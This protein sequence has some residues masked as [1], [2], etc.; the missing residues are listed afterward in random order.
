MSANNI[1]EI[2]LNNDDSDSSSVVE[3]K[4]VQGPKKTDRNANQNEGNF[5]DTGLPNLNH[6]PEILSPPNDSSLNFS[7]EFQQK[8]AAGQFN[9]II[10]KEETAR[11]AEESEMIN[12][13]SDLDYHDGEFKS[14]LRHHKIYQCMKCDFAAFS[15]TSF[16]THTEAHNNNNSF[17]CPKCPFIAINKNTFRAHFICKHSNVKKPFQCQICHFSTYFQSAL[18]QHIKIHSADR[19]YECQYCPYAAISKAYL[20]IHLR[21]HFTQPKYPCSV[22]SF[23]ALSADQLKNHFICHNSEYQFETNN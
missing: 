1:I 10:L 13:S 12:L 11:F 15:R 20:A 3:I 14:T 22:C 6:L 21:N 23:S 9:H 19:S 18:Q 16:K 2:E 8:S 7:L 5:I 17:K 4:C